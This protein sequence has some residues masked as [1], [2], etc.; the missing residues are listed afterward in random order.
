LLPQ[1]PLSAWVSSA[2]SVWTA[3]SAGTNRS[4]TREIPRWHSPP[5]SLAPVA[6]FGLVL[7]VLLLYLA[8]RKEVSVRF[9]VRA[10]E[11]GGVANTVLMWRTVTAAAIMLVLFFAGWSTSKVAIVTG[12]LLLIARTVEPDKGL[13]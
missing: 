7:T 11:L 9:S 8:Y 6:F 12:S 2:I 10:E 4:T 1:S 3:G 5:A 13:P